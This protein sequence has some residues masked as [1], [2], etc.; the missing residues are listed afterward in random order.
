MGEPIRLDTPDS[1]LYFSYHLVKKEYIKINAPTRHEPDA[2]YVVTAPYCHWI[3]ERNVTV[4]ALLAYATRNAQVTWSNVKCNV[5]SAIKEAPTEEV[6]N[7]TTNQMY[8]K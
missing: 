1:F 4:L 7:Q 3:Q 5:K 2:K 6:L 8:Q